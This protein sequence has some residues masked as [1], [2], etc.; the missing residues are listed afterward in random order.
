VKHRPLERG[1]RHCHN[2]PRLPD[3]EA[4]KSASPVPFSCPFSC[5]SLFLV[6][7][8]KFRYPDD[9]VSLSEVLACNLLVAHLAD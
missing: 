9:T 4:A 2:S 5:P 8:E 7:G 6:I 1:C 3:P